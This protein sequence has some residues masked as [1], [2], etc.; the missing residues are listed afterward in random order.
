MDSEFWKIPPDMNC[1]TPTDYDFELRPCEITYFSKCNL[2]VVL[3]LLNV[4]FFMLNCIHYNFT[5]INFCTSY[6][7]TYTVKVFF[8]L[9]S[10][11][12]FFLHV[13]F[14]DHL[15]VSFVQLFTG[16]LC[17]KTIIALR[18]FKYRA[19]FTCTLNLSYDIF[20][21]HFSSTLRAFKCHFFTC[22][23]CYILTYHYVFVCKT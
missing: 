20:H 2:F 17:P 22:I 23:S 11:Q 21:E 12:T 4:Y 9:N 15:N 6:F 13:K 16:I 19:F 5:L 3:L 8:S 10:N 14:P 18:T 7:L 1:I